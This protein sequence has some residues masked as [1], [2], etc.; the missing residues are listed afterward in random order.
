MT[1]EN[2]WT[3]KE[4]YAQKLSRLS[5][6]P[7]GGH[8]KTCIQFRVTHLKQ[9]EE[10]DLM[11]F[12]DCVSSVQ[13]L[14]DTIPGSVFLLSRGSFSCPANLLPWRSSSSGVYKKSHR[15]APSSENVPGLERLLKAWALTEFP[16]S[17]TSMSGPQGPLD[18]YEPLLPLL[19]GPCMGI[20]RECYLRGAL[21]AQ[22]CES[23][24]YSR[25]RF[26]QSAS[27]CTKQ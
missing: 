22:V 13:Q 21:H 14:A 5:T 23:G 15:R 26:M 10:L 25:C 1:N 18:P 24:Q 9:A 6:L 11:F 7:S 17:L 2:A 4:K 8:S 20:W 19:M 3:D 12:T 27:L 16:Q